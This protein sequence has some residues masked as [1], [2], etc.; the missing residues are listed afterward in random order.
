MVLHL[1]FTLLNFHLPVQYNKSTSTLLYMSK[2]FICGNRV[3]HSQ[4]FNCT[5]VKVS[6]CLCPCFVFDAVVVVVLVF[7][8]YSA[9]LGAFLLTLFSG[10]TPGWAPG[11]ICSAK[12]W[13]NHGWPGAGHVFTRC[14]LVTPCPLLSIFICS[15]HS[16]SLHS[17]SAFFLE[18]TILI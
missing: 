3:T 2:L 11:I 16:S 9:V 7:G 17:S 10:I 1:L 12:V 4:I 14:I 15:T 5:P 8:L 6:Q 18:L 13:M